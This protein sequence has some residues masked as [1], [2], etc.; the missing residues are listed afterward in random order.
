M[1][2]L[3]LWLGNELYGDEGV[4]IHAVRKLRHELKARKKMGLK[5]P[6]KIRIIAVEAKNMYNLGEGLTEEMAK[7]VPSIVEKVKKVLKQIK[8]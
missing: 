5:I 2:T 3:V 8:S 4:G 6:S 1:K 7:A